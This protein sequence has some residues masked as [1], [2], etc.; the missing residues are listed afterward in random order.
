M[1]KIAATFLLLSCQILTVFDC[2]IFE[3]ISNKTWFDE[4]SSFAGVTIVFTKSETG[5]KKAIRQING[6]GIPVLFTE[7]YDIEIRQ[8]TIYLINR[9]KEQT[10]NKPNDF[11]I[12]NDRQGLLS[13]GKQLIVI[14][15]RDKSCLKYGTR[16][17]GRRH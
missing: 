5:Q 14:A 12:Y 7:I 13:K 6:S 16:I 1:I 11:L 8:D 15:R 2:D 9:F 17:G 3:K 10:N 4:S